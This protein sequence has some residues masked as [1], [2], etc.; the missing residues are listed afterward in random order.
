[1]MDK[2][3]LSP[4]LEKFRD[5]IESSLKP[6]IAIRAEK[7]DNLALWQSKF[8]GLP[9]LPKGYEYP[10]GIQDT[11]L[12]LLAQINFEEASDLEGFPQS[13]ILQFYIGGDDFYGANWD[14]PTKQDNFRVVY[15]PEVSKI[16]SDLVTDF[17]FLPEQTELPLFESCSLQF[18]KKIAP[19]GMGDYEFEKIFGQRFFEEFGDQEEDVCHEYDNKFPSQGHKIGGYAFFTQDDPRAVGKGAVVGKDI[20]LLQIDTDD[21]ADIMWGDS[22]V[23]NFFISQADLEKRDFS[24]VLYT[25]DCC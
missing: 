4:E 18:E 5:K 10:K 8:G 11:P 21:D 3:E 17:S 14:N 2:L 7:N 25:W 6:F 13:G 22:G 16:E 19:V 1:M 20:L 24:Q 12:F 15:F 23:G 9:Y